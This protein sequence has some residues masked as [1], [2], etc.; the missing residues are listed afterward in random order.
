MSKLPKYATSDF[1]P[2]KDLS[3]AE[4][5]VWLELADILRDLHGTKISDADHELMRQYC[6]LTVTRNRAWSEFNK[7]PEFY[8]RIV[9]G[10]EADKQTPKV[11]VKENEYYKTWL[12]CSKRLDALMKEMELNPKSR[13]SSRDAAAAKIKM[14]EGEDQ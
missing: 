14:Y 8:T 3:D 11:V 5:V 4:L 12:E 10:L 6:Q 7:K 1:A 2:P 9:T 13:A